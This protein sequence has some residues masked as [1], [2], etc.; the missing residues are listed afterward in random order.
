MFSV[1]DLVS[2][3]QEYTDEELVEIRGNIGSYSMEA[4]EALN[5]VISNKG[6]QEKLLQRLEEKMKI[7]NEIQRIENETQKL[8]A[9]GTDV[10]F[11]K[12]MIYSD[13]LTTEKVHEIIDNKIAENRL[14][15]E[16]KEIKP[17]TIIGSIVG[18]GIASFIGGVLWGLQMIYSK[19]IFAILFI[20]LVL[21]CYGIIS[22]STKQSKKNNVV[23]VATV[24]STLAAL[25]IGQLL[26]RIFGYKG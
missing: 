14:H 2:K 5:I 25:L 22:I 8:A 19:K 26:Y 21:L 7:V 4:Q 13:Y 3:Y 17:R 20:G 23:V 15:E 9:G 16:D 11:L 10:S 18:G 24:I 12:K 6:G 1:D